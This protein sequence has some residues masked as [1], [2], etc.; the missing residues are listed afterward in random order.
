MTRKVGY[1]SPPDYTK[2]P[3][4][5][6]GNPAGRRRGSRNIATVIREQLARKVRGSDGKFVQFYELIGLQLVTKVAKG[7][8][9]WLPLLIRYGELEARSDAEPELGPKDNRLMAE[10]LE[11]FNHDE[12]E[13]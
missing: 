11:A 3:K 12:P 9:R 7:E 10:F 2:W 8:L 6:S 1:G 13:A 5:T 4:G